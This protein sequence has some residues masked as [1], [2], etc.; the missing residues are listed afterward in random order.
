D[1]EK[2]M[3]TC[4]AGTSVQC[5]GNVP[6]PDLTSVTASDNCGVPVKS[7]VGDSYTTNGCVITVTRTYRATDAYNNSTD[8]TQVITVQDTIAPSFTFVPTDATVQCLAD[9]PALASLIA[10]ATDNCGSVT[11]SSNRTL[12]GTCP[13][14][15]TNT[16]IATDPCGNST[17]NRQV[18]TVQDTIAPSFTFVPTDTTVQCLAFPPT[19]LFLSATAT[20]NCGTVTVS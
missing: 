5:F 19:P 18:I 4:P 16:F 2:P 13:T 7:F 9:V 17:T 1:T 12:G 8:C 3:I 14:L 6:A 10:T 15:V 11:V 20:D